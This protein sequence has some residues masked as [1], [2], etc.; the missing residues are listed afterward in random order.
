MCIRDSIGS[1][2]FLVGFFSAAYI[3]IS[4]LYRLSQGMQARLVV[5]NPFFYIALTCMMIGT[6]LF[7]GGF[8]AELIS[9]TSVDRNNYL[10]EKVIGNGDAIRKI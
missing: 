3:G 1:L 2:M 10:I 8:L 4:K 9:R 7:L 5:D 6:L